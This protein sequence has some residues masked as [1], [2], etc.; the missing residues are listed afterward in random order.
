MQAC[1]MK[2]TSK[3]LS[4][5]ISYKCKVKENISK[6][7]G[8]FWFFFLSFSILIDFSY[9]YTKKTT[10]VHSFSKKNAAISKKKS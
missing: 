7:L 5:L 8:S 1:A 10:K 4:A 3:L 6:E 9:K 2:A